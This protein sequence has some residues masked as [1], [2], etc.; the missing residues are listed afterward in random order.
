MNW[1]YLAAM[2]DGEGSVMFK[3]L[4]KKSENTPVLTPVIGVY[5]TYELVIRMIHAFA[6]CGNVT[7]G[8]RPNP[9]HK[10]IYAWT[11]YNHK[12]AQYVLGNVLPLLIIKKRQ[13]ELVVEFCLSRKGKHSKYTEDEIAMVDEVKLLNKTGRG[14]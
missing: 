9:K 5:N 8:K 7:V 11:I 3:R 12:D 13:A 14:Q 1:S 4:Q 6:Q 2:I 10:T